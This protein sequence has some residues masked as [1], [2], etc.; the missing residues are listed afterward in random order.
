MALPTLCE[1]QFDTLGKRAMWT[2]LGP[3]NRRIGSSCV[4]AVPKAFGLRGKTGMGNQVK[5]S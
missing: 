4:V 3:S 1:V 2:K 5:E